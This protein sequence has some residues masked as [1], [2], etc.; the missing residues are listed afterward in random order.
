MENIIKKLHKCISLSSK[1]SNGE[2]QFFGYF[3][4][5]KNI[6]PFNKDKI[7]EVIFKNVKTNESRVK[8]GYTGKDKGL[9]SRTF[10][11][12]DDRIKANYDVDENLWERLI[13]LANNDIYNQLCVGFSR[14]SVDLVYSSDINRIKRESFIE[15]KTSRNTN[16]PLYAF[17]ELLKNYILTLKTSKD[18]ILTKN[19]IKNK[20]IPA[21]NPLGE[22]KDIVELS[23]LAPKFYYSHF[24]YSDK[25]IEKYSKKPYFVKQFLDLINDFNKGNKFNNVK[26]NLYYIDLSENEMKKFQSS[27]GLSNQTEEKL[28][29]NFKIKNSLIRKNWKQI[30]TFED[31]KKLIYWLSSINGFAP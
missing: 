11:I 26:F 29:K 22:C 18:H 23:L 27:L 1:V 31:W 12:S 14:E 21:D 30:K 15:L 8:R 9:L 19:L 28:N 5:E 13:L 17:I 2:N 4:N 6:I 16:N 20:A 24:L 7:F 25:I 10:D 3:N